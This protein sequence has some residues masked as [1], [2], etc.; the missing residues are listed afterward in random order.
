MTETSLGAGFGLLSVDYLAPG[1]LG[2][3]A[4][5]CSSSS[6]LATSYTFRLLV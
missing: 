1:P 4:K 3:P 2:R 6:A 5:P